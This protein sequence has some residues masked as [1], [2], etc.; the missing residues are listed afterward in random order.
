MNGGVQSLRVEKF[1]RQL[2]KRI[3]HARAADEAGVV[4]DGKA[5]NEI[6]GIFDKRFY[7]LVSVRKF[8]SGVKLVLI[9]GETYALRSRAVCENEFTFGIYKHVVLLQ[10]VEIFVGKHVSET[11]NIVTVAAFHV[12]K[13][14]VHN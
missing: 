2:R 11:A 4:A 7:K 9:V 6:F 13:Q 5:H 12:Q 10:N 8:G 14:V 1:E 3:T